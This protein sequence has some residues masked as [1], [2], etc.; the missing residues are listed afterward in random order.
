[1]G[2]PEEGFSFFFFR[3]LDQLAFFP[4]RNKR[5]NAFSKRERARERENERSAPSK[6]SKT[7]CKCSKEEEERKRGKKGER[8]ERSR[9]KRWF[10]GR[11]RGRESQR[12]TPANTKSSAPRFSLVLK[13]RRPL[14]LLS[15]SFLSASKRSRARHHGFRAECGAPRWRQGE[16][17]T[18]EICF[19]FFDDLD[20]VLAYLLF[21]PLSS[22][23]PRLTLAQFS[24]TYRSLRSA[25]LE[26]RLLAES[27]NE[28]PGTAASAGDDPRLRRR[29]QSSS[30]PRAATSLRPP[31]LPRRSTGTT[32]RLRWTLR[33]GRRS[34]RG[35]R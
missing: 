7:K 29:R 17:K 14:F 16:E 9:L 1:M 15:L 6:K 28:L 30:Q 27:R 8:R 11:G 18:R 22:H 10:P 24:Y 32:R 23:A 3:F 4:K 19:S 34:S 2:S 21:L 20:V 33:E 13:S 35:S 25:L 31:P 26:L 5:N 12:S